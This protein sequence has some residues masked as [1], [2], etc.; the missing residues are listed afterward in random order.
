[1]LDHLMYMNAATRQRQQEI[2]ALLKTRAQLKA[3]KPAKAGVGGW[4]QRILK[5]VWTLLTF[6]HE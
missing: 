3:L 5:P 1:M 2:N 4:Q 6:A